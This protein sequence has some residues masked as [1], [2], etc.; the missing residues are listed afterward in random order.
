MSSAAL[1]RI[2]SEDAVVFGSLARG[3]FTAGSDIDWTL[4][5]DG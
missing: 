2:D 4:L 5:V 1:R 3:E